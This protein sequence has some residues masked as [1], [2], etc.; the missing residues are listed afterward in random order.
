M[1]STETKVVPYPLPVHGVIK[2]SVVQTLPFILMGLLFLAATFLFPMGWNLIPLALSLFILTVGYLMMF[3][4]KN[5]FTIDENGIERRTCFKT[6]R[7]DW[8]EIAEVKMYDLGIIKRI[9][10]MG[11]K[12]PSL[13]KQILNPGAPI[14]S[15]PISYVKGID[16]QR[17]Q[18]TF[19][20]ILS[21]KPTLSQGELEKEAAA[22][23]TKVKQVKIR[24][25][26]VILGYL[27][28]AIG[29]F[30]FVV[31][32]KELFGFYFDTTLILLALMIQP[33]LCF[34]VGIIIG[35]WVG[36]WPSFE[37]GMIVLVSF[38]GNVNKL[39]SGEINYGIRGWL[40]LIIG[41]AIAVGCLSVGAFV[42]IKLKN[43]YQS[44]QSG[45]EL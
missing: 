9:D 29:D 23:K 43:R 1:E 18:M 8:E 13:C 36:H 16:A 19:H 45:A 35:L 41:V 24:F 30:A 28:I 33:L 6:H 44:G 37:I 12:K 20:T 7:F 3:T 4:D 11:A 32:G 34:I 31:A 26:P 40:G 39:I 25:L 27:I 21:E 15:I 17:L 14:T 22:S 10:L 42:G 2:M 5:S 38:V